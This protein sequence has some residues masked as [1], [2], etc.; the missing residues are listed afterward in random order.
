MFGYIS[1]NKAEMKFKDYDV[2]HSYYCGLC[3]VLKEC[4]GRRGQ[5]TLSFDMTFLVILLTGLY[6]PDTK[7]E[8]VRCIAHPMQ[9][10]AAKTN[11]FTEYA[12]AINMLLSYYKCEDDWAD[13]H[14]KKAFVAAKLLHSKI[15]KIEKLY[16]VKCKVISENLAQISK[17]EAENEQNL[18]LMSGLFGNIMA[19]IFDRTIEN[20]GLKAMAARL[21]KGII[22]FSPLA[23]G[24]LTNRYL[25]GIPA[26]SR[27]HTD[28]R[29][30]KEKD[31]T[32]EKIA[33]IN[34]LNDI[35]QARG[36][37]L[38]EMA[39]AWLLSHDEITT[40]LIGAS[41]TSQI[42]DNIKAVQ[43]TSFTAEELEAIDRISK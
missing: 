6:E 22:T 19:E 16:P 12:A 21:H 15:K 28:G 4:Y 24:L 39:L 30:L 13:E 18:D 38:A 8:M 29:F 32:P 11:E 10:H 26:D 34:A 17:Y 25:Q 36:Q 2:Y 27:V 42:L 23:Q 3:K 20:N 37:T 41:K 33:Q 7:T 43:N 5:V 1:I 40:V 35:A 9:K 31:I 14:R